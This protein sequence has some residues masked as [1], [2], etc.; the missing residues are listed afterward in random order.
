MRQASVACTPRRTHAG[1]TRRTPRQA[2]ANP[3]KQGIL[4]DFVVAPAR[5]CVNER[6]GLYFLSMDTIPLDFWVLVSGFGGSAV[7]LPIALAIGAWRAH[8]LSWRSAA[9]WL[10]LVGVA[11]ACVAA[12]KIAFIGWGVGVRS[13]DFTGISGHSALATA[14]FP[15]LLYIMLDT[16]RPA[17]RLAGA[18]VGLAFGALV[19]A[20]RLVLH[21]H[22]VSE[23]VAG[24]LLGA[25]VAVVYIWFTRRIPASRMHPWLVAC[26]AL[27]MLGAL[28]GLRAPTQRWVTHIALSLSGHEQPYIRARWKKG[29]APRCLVRA[30]CHT[31][32]PADSLRT[33]LTPTPAPAPAALDTSV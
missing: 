6:V 3:Q 2:A 11:G 10:A 4:E 20:S 29:L 23:I 1:P 27:L 21:A 33:R 28:H 15:V 14:V 30:R 25:L 26:T 32:A 16:A 17:L 7:M 22:S 24:C 8:S 31:I 19:G 13:L 9:I 12:T 5:L 18:V